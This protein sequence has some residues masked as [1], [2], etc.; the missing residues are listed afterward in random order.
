M[1]REKCEARQYSDQMCCTK[2]GLNWD[3]N[4]PD[5]PECGSA[6]DKKVI[7]DFRKRRTQCAR[8]AALLSIRKLLGMGEP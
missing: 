5:P 7:E 2:C 8:D 3:A 6:D 1:R 4:D